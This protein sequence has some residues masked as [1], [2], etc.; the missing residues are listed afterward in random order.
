MESM[1]KSLNMLK[2]VAQSNETQDQ[3]EQ[4]GRVMMNETELS[5][6]S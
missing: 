3:R 1:D 5:F 6:Q 2:L 4:F